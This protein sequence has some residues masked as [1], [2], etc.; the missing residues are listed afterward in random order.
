MYFLAK[1]DHASSILVPRSM[2]V[3][4]AGLVFNSSTAG[5]Q[6]VSTSATL[7]IRSMIQ[8]VGQKVTTPFGG[9]TM[10][11]RVQPA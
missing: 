7:V 8:A 3:K 10:L 1:E 5:F 2:S 9:E 11:V 4:Y 6:P